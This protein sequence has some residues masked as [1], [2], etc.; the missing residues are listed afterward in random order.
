MTESQVGLVTGNGSGGFSLSSDQNSGGTLT[1]PSG[2]G[3]YNVAT[4]GRV[5]L[6]GS[7]F[8][9]SAPVLYM[10]NPNQAFI[11]GTDAAVSFG[12]MTPQQ[13]GFALSGT[14]AGGSLPPVD[15]A[16]SNVVGI[17]IAGTNTLDLSQDISSNNGLSVSQASDAT[18]PSAGNPTRVVVTQSGNQTQI[19][20]L[21]SSTEFFALDAPSPANGDTTARVDIFQ[22]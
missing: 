14:Y 19:L 9:N 10:V 2:T 8:Q 18:A 22:Q 13:S 5:T 21:V 12:F 1:S 16:V 3:G 17:A 20:Y 6:S 4:N 15:P 7:G 11:I